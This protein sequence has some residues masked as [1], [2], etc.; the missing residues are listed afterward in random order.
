[1]RLESGRA[2]TRLQAVRGRISALIFHQDV[3]RQATRHGGPWLLTRVFSVFQ[4][5]VSSAESPPLPLFLAITLGK[6]NFL[7]EA[8]CKDFQAV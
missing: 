7:H 4:D 1:M 3:P 6:K 8:F 2:E 5:S